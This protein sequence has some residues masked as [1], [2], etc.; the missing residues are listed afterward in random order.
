MKQIGVKFEINQINAVDVNNILNREEE[1]EE[2]MNKIIVDKN[3]DVFAVIITDIVNCDSV[4][5]ALGNKVDIINKA[6]N[7]VLVDNK[8]VLKGVVSRKKQVVP[9]IEKVIN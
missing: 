3:L 2:M 1:L 5:L 9:A 8:A 7:V 6:F 4:V